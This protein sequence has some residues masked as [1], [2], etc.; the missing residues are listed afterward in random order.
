MDKEHLIELISSSLI[1][2]AK[3]IK[4]YES[5]SDIKSY[6]VKLNLSQLRTISKEFILWEKAHKSIFLNY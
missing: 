4:S 5:S 2:E 6:L 3:N 1:I